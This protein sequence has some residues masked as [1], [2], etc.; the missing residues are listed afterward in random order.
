MSTNTQITN[1]PT[2]T[3]TGGSSAFS[4]MMST[5]YL[6]LIAVG[7]VL[8]FAT[9]GS[10]GSDSINGTIAGY[11]LTGVGILLMVSYLCYNLYNNRKEQN[12]LAKSNRQLFMS[13]I[14]TCGPFLLILGVIGYALYL[15]TTFKYRI[16]DGNVAPSYTTFTNISVILI[17]I[18]LAIFFMGSK[19]ENF[20][21]TGRLDRVYS[22][23]IYMVGIIYIAAVITIGVILTYFTTDG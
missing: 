3:I 15:L 21:N 19:K 1:M 8:L 7:I 2:T 5:L 23:L 14:Y 10:S 13:F 4:S 16:S 11:S 6:S 20:K 9:I 17:L 12:I 18:Q 22:M